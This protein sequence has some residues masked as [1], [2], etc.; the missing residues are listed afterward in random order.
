MEEAQGKDNGEPLSNLLKILV[1]GAAETGKSC[2]VSAACDRDI[3]KTYIPTIGVDFC[4]KEITVDKKVIKLQIWDTAGQERFRAIQTSYYKGA[5][6][7]LLVYDVTSKKSLDDV[8]SFFK[9]IKEHSGLSATV[10]LIG[11]KTDMV[12]REI[13]TAVGKKKA[14]DIGVLFAETTATDKNGVQYAINKLISVIVKG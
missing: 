13:S 6:G 4:M 5:A 2:F 3:N 11:N 14:E 8:D 10:L 7:I 1:V 12:Q 9:E